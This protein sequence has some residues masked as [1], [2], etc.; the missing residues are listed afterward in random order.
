MPR[1]SKGARLW[2]RKRRGRT[3]QWVILDHGREFRTSAGPDDLRAAENA[4]AQYLA[5]KR[6]PQFGD[7]HPSRVLIADVLS[8]YGEHHGPTT[9][10]AD[11]IG[12]AIGK[13]VEFFGDKT[14]STITGITCNAYV[15]WRTQQLNA[16]AKRDGRP[17]KVSTARRELVVLGAALR[18]CWKEGKIDRLIPISLPSQPGPRQRHLNRSE[19]AA[20]LAGALGWDRYGVRHRTKINRHLA[21]FILIALYTGTRH[22]A[23][24]RLRWIPNTDSGWIDLASGVMYRRASGAVDK[25]KRRPP[26]PLT[27]RLLPHLRRWR[28]ATTTHVIEY[29]GRPLN[30]KERRAWRTARELAGLGPDVTPHVLRHTCATMLLQLGVSVYDVAGVLGASEDVIRRTYGHHAHDHLRQAVAA[31]SRRPP[32][33][34]TPMKSVNKRG[35]TRKISPNSD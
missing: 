33:H 22:D 28:R 27:P 7:G 25:G 18:W 17:I 1:R 4:L 8:H 32:A 35:Q 3:A 6:Q 12:V 29:A 5:N 15:R 14:L 31:F 20:L 2:L 26:V 23:I 10:R 16:R 21:R 34:E 24:L 30:S 11:L 13:L 19:V 9:R